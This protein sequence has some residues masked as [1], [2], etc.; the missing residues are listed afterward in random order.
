M[1][2]KESIEIAYSFLHQK[3]NV[4]IHSSLG[5]QRE[6][7]EYA[8]ASYADEMNRELLAAVSGGREDFLKVHSRFEEDLT[9]A[10]ATLERML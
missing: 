5:W 6:D 8:V 7:I 4:Y 10:V 3:R 1:I 9:T 2:P